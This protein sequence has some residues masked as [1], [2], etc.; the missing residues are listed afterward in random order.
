MDR[1]EFRHGPQPLA[2]SRSAAG[3]PF[4][5]RNRWLRHEAQNLDTCR[6]NTYHDNTGSMVAVVGDGCH[7]VVAHDGIENAFVTQR[8][9][10]NFN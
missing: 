5:K 10:L 8:I 2:P 3:V 1:L 4:M 7:K 6:A 9:T